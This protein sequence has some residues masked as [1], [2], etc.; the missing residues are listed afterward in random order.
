MGTRLENGYVTKTTFWEDFTIADAFGIDA[1]QGT[2]DRSFRDWKNNLEYVTELAMVMSWKSCGWYG[3]NE[4][5]T[6]L[7]SD[8]YHKVDGWCCDNLKGQD[9]EYYLD[10]TD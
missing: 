2:F 1:I 7:Y 9:L 10:T 5:Y 6:K 8:L 4:Q 3:K